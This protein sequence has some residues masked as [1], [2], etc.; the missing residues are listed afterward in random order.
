MD[1]IYKDTSKIV[2][3]T[4][5]EELETI[6]EKKIKELRFKIMNHIIHNRS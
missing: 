1:G 6:Q 4:Y 5:T 3:G 2:S